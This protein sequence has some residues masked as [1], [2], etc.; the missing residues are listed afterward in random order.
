MLEFETLEGLIEA[1]QVVY[2]EMY[3]M[4]EKVKQDLDNGIDIEALEF[5]GY[6]GGNVFVI[7][8]TE[9]LRVIEGSEG[10]LETHASQFD[11]AFLTR[12]ASFAVIVN[13]TSDSGGAT[14]FIP[15]EIYAYSGAIL[16][17]ILFTNYAGNTNSFIDN[18]DA[19]L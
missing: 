14:Y 3:G 15:R 7:E 4:M 8:D 10:T 2:N 5:M 16:M 18:V 19:G 11:I 12:D 1:P 6:L 13:M 17:S 9:D